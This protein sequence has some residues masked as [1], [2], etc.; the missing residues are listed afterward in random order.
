LSEQ[1]HA[2]GLVVC[3]RALRDEGTSYHYQPPA[4]YAEPDA[5]LTAQLSSALTRSGLPYVSGPTWTTDAPFRE[6]Y[7][8]VA[9]F[10]AQGILTVDMEA[11]ALFSASTYLGSACA[12]LFAIGDGPRAGR[13]QTDPDRNSMYA[14]LEKL[15]NT[16]VEVLA[17]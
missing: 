8:E 16:A 4:D 13:W 6:T 9:H 3:S 11:A 17:G 1:Q 2:G 7:A 14:G 12:A 5:G 10:E 15:A